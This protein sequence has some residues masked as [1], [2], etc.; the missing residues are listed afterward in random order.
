MSPRKAKGAPDLDT[1]QKH[2]RKLLGEGTVRTYY[3]IVVAALS[4]FPTDPM[5]LLAQKHLAYSSRHTYQAALC[6]WAKFMKDDEL[7]ARLK[8]PELKRAFKDSR[9]DEHQTRDHHSVQPFS[10]EEERRIYAALQ[11]WKQDYLL[12]VWQWPAVSMMFS[13]GLRAGA[14]LVWLA[15]RDVDS[16]LRSGVELVIVTKGS[17]ERTLPAILVLEELQ[18]L[19]DLEQSWETL[20]DLIVTDRAPTSK[21]KVQNAYERLRLCVKKLAEETDIPA[22]DMHT[23]RFRHNAAQRLY[24]ATK[25]IKKVQAFLGH[26][27]INTTLGYLKKD[28]TAEI[29]TD[30]LAAMKRDLE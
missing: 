8:S 2:L 14:D 5:K 28:E 25:D 9:R 7:L 20:A 17:K 23:H 24:A 6:C 3:R 4:Q 18:W 13:L 16:A 19:A 1:F 11:K 10:R 15:H 12:P 26:N 22:Q 21:Y 29:G 27:N 30:L